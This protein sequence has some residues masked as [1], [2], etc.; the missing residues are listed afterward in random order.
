VIPGSAA[1]LPEG[2]GR[3]RGWSVCLGG[4]VEQGHGQRGSGRDSGG[5]TEG[6]E[7]GEV[8]GK[9]KEGVAEPT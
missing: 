3:R 1:K 2:G 7:R 5:G 4:V 8:E 9:E 6:V